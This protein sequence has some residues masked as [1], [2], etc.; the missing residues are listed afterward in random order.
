M[1]SQIPLLSRRKLP[2]SSNRETPVTLSYLFHLPPQK[3]LHCFIEIHDYQE[4]SLVPYNWNGLYD[5]GDNNRRG[6]PLL[7][8][9]NQVLQRAHSWNT[10]YT[11]P[12]LTHKDLGAMEIGFDH[13]EESAIRLNV[14]VTPKQVSPA[15]EPKTDTLTQ[16][17]L[18]FAFPTPTAPS[19]N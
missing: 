12:L 17:G 3:K 1:V 9:S 7:I 4:Q 18:D 6:K 14:R 2:K 19:Y 8:S 5:K 15:R 11:K 10:I 13:A 16:V